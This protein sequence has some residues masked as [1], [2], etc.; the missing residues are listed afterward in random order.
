MKIS[1]IN[2][3]T[4]FKAIK[5]THSESK[6]VGELIRTYRSKGNLETKAQIVDIFTPHIEKEARTMAEENVNLSVKDYAQNLNLRLLEKMETIS[7][8]FHPVTE[9]TNNLNNYKPQEDDYI[10]ISENKSIEDLTPIEELYLSV[11]DLPVLKDRM[12]SIVSE[13]PYIALRSKSIVHDYLDGYTH[14]DLGEKYA[15]TSD[16]IRNIIESFARKIRIADNS[17]EDQTK[18]YVR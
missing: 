17:S 1:E 18:G 9:L 10:T 16:R 14:K 6:K 15:L 4:N 7:L 8:K 12:H 11:D 2:N 13:T 3:K 5:L